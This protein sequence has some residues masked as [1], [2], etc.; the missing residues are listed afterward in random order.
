MIAVV[1][2]LQFMFCMTK[3]GLPCIHPTGPPGPQL[4]GSLESRTDLGLFASRGRLITDRIYTCLICTNHMFF[5]LLLSSFSPS[6]LLVFPP[7]VY[8]PSRD[9]TDI[10]W[11]PPGSPLEVCAQPTH[12]LLNILSTSEFWP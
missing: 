2:I 8:P 7:L 11:N 4:G 10:P 1:A 9:P 5:F 6:F 3:L 12:R